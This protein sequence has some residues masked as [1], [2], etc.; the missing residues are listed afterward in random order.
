MVAPLKTMALYEEKIARTPS[1]SFRNARGMC[2]NR[3]LFGVSSFR[4]CYR[5]QPSSLK[6]VSPSD[7]RTHMIGPMIPRH[8][9]SQVKSYANISRLH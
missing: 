7:K 5:Y 4:F 2:G 9:F 3:H 1:R 6:A 8:S